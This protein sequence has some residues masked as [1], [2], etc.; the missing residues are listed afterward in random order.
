MRSI[1]P[2]KAAAVLRAKALASATFDDVVYDSGEHVFAFISEGRRAATSALWA[3]K[4]GCSD[5]DVHVDDRQTAAWIIYEVAK[6]GKCPTLDTTQDLIE[7]RNELDGVESLS[8]FFRYSA[9]WISTNW[10]GSDAAIHIINLAREV[11]EEEEKEDGAKKKAAMEGQQWSVLITMSFDMA[12]RERLYYPFFSV[13][14]PHFVLRTTPVKRVLQIPQSGGE[15]VFG[16]KTDNNFLSRNDHI[17]CTA[18]LEHMT[19]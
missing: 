10:D 15:H 8:E 19:T 6:A 13:S 12:L 9:A 16:I 14:S 11:F 5:D 1:V 7:L 18:G 2:E 17:N 3:A 4:C